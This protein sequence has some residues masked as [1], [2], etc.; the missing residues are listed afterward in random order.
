MAREVQTEIQVSENFTSWETLPATNTISRIPQGEY[1]TVIVRD[2]LPL[3]Q[4]PARYLRLRC[5]AVEQ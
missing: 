2:L 4:S 3:G 5:V 1:E